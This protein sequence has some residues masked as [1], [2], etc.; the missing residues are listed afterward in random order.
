MVQFPH[1]RT[2]AQASVPSLM[3][4]AI[5]IIIIIINSYY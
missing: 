2:S 1:V 3:V 5:I 4:Q